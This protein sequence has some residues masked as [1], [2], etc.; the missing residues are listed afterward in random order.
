MKLTDKDI[1][2]T[3]GMRGGTCETV[4]IHSKPMTNDS[5][6]DEE[7][8]IGEVLDTGHVFTY[9]DN[10]EPVDIDYKCYCLAEEVRPEPEV[11]KWMGVQ[12]NGLKTYVGGDSLFYKTKEGALKDEASEAAMDITTGEVFYGGRK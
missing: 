11:Y 12:F 9:R 8:F 10:G 1:G 7:W 2:K 5:C 3:Y 6:S 4:Y